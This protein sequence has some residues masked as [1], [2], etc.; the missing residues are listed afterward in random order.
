MLRGDHNVQQNTINV[1]IK[2]LLEISRSWRVLALKVSSSK[3]PNF[4]LSNMKLT[5]FRFFKL[6]LSYN[7]S[8]FNFIF[9]LLRSHR[10]AKGQIVAADVF[11]MKRQPNAQMVS[12]FQLYILL[13]LFRPAQ[14]RI[15]KI[16]G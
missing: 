13:K 14:D 11:F 15:T 5:N 2:V 9:R 12:I 8:D 4:V 16:K 1:A 10:V 7:K 6:N 3:V